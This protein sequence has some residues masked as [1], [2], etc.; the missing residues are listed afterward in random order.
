MALTVAREAI[1]CLD[2]T[3]EKQR[4]FSPFESTIPELIYRKAK[5]NADKIAFA[6]DHE[7]VG[8]TFG[9]VKKD[10]E[11]I[12][13]G[14][15]AS[16]LKSQDRVLIAG[17]NHSQLIIATLAVSRAG[18]IFALA[19]P[20]FRSSEQ[21]R[22]LLVAGDFRAII[23]FSPNGRSDPMYDLLLEVCPELKS[24]PPGRL[25][26][27]TLP[28][29]SHVI[30]ADEDHRHAGVFTLSD[31]A[32]NA[33]KDGIE[34][35]PNYTQWN[36]HRLAA[37]GFSLGSTGLPKAVG[38]TH[39]QLI[40]G[41]RIAAHVIGITSETVLCC[42]LPLFRMPVFC[43]VVFTPF[44]AESRSVF[45]DASPV[46]RELFRSIKKY[47]CSC[48]LSNA[49]ALRFGLRT[50]FTHKISLPSVSTIILLGERV[51][52]ELLISITRVMP[53]ARRIAVG[54]ILA[55]VGAIPVISDNTTNLV[56][57][58]GRPL[59]GFEVSVDKIEA[60]STEKRTVGELKVRPVM[61]TKFIGFGPD[62][63][64]P[65]EWISTGDIVAQTLDGNIEVLAHKEDIIYDRQ[66]RL[67]E[68]WRLE[69]AMANY[70]QIKGV[71]VLQAWPGSPIVAI[72]IPKH[73]EC[74]PEF[75]KTDL[76]LICKK[77]NLPIPDK[78]SLI[79]DFPRINT[80]IQKYKLRELLRAGFLQLY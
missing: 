73:L 36:P 15:V 18:L 56:K 16:G 10:V 74:V 78:F 60:L 3:R 19:N 6:F 68:H 53:Q 7:K 67:L 37:I 64:S 59:D 17:Q 1:F 48:V 79:D 80:K 39:F 46:P 55:E 28:S 38:L 29:L 40:N 71:Q 22:H 27:A 26:S 20:S 13:A 21:L 77:S 35:L 49:V 70:V 8:F 75:I 69:R 4:D 34:K 45:S 12:A 47:Q 57:A 61:K 62:F 52:A 32:M 51:T 66:D 44:L 31:I 76:S 63:N 72:V 14:L 25:K 5:T 9:A 54:M 23:L 11:G 30:L 43:L 65:V 41:C 2:F 58:I 50:V 24:C 42:A 33:T